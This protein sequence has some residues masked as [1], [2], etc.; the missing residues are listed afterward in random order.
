MTSTTHIS[1]L[2]LSNKFIK[3]THTTH[4]SPSA[5][6]HN[7]SPHIST[8][9]HPQATSGS[10]YGVIFIPNAFTLV[11]FL[12]PPFTSRINTPAGI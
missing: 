12:A 9:P 7:P 1:T 11:A 8:S 4:K 6:S 3:P 5:G 10:S 2:E